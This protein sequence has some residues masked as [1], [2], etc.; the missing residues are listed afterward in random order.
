[1]TVYTDHK[2]LEYFKNARVLNQRQARWSMFL[3]RFDFFIVYRP[4]S[5]QGNPDALS[6]QSYL[7]LKP[8]DVTFEQQKSILLKPEQF[9]LMALVTKD[10]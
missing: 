8:G 10:S 3:S 7:A 4:G 9:R 6:R 2:N 5:Q 1:M